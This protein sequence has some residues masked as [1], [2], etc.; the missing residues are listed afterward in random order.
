WF[1]IPPGA[2]PNDFAALPSLAWVLSVAAPTTTLFMALL[3]GYRQFFDQSRLRVALSTVLSPVLSLSIVALALFTIKDSSPSR[4]FLFTFGG[5]SV[6][7]LL[8]Y[9]ATIWIHQR[10]KLAAGAYAKNVL[11]IGQVSAIGWM[12]S[13]FRSNVPA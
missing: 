6:L 4:V 1:E 3:G 2:N 5:L 7:G 8:G 10:R 12:T 11:L 9:R 13:H